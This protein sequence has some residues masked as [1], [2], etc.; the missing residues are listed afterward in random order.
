MSRDQAVLLSCLI[1][2]AVAVAFSVRSFR[3]APVDVS[4]PDV[5]HEAVPDVEP[6]S[7]RMGPIKMYRNV[8]ALIR[9]AQHMQRAFQLAAN[10]MAKVDL[11]RLDDEHVEE[12]WW[13]N[14]TLVFYRPGQQAEREASAMHR[15]GEVVYR[16]PTSRKDLFAQY[17]VTHVPTYLTFEDGVE[18][19]RSHTPC[20]DGACP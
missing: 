5:E 2:L 3:P 7:G 19:R 16:V 20:P 18:V 8:A 10:E 12:A 4:V 1:V 6:D 13:E 9:Y 11:P 17:N 15:R 14:A